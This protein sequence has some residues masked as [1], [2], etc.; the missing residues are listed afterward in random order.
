M[1]IELNVPSTLAEITLGQYQ[2]YLK[3]AENN[4]NGNFLHAK[5]IE[6]FCGIPLSES[7][8]LKISSVAAIIDILEE[9]L[10][11][12]PEHVERFDLDGV[13]YGFIPDIDE[14]TLEEYICLDE[15]ASDWENMHVAMNALYRPIK[16][17]NT[18]KYNIEEYNE[19][20]AY[21]MANMPM[22]AV[23]GSLFFFLNLGLELSSHTISYLDQAEMTDI[24]RKA[25]LQEDGGG[26]NQF[27]HSLTE[28]LRDLK[29][30]LN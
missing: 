20:D 14:M 26:I 3:I 4:P 25:I 7:Y 30:S 21:K 11:S 1:K 17:S 5:M 16:D 15:N 9:L 6:I 18:D 29:I 8:K 10:D 22:S 24:Q 27:T 23:T 12:K 28:I 19:K 13:S 2:K